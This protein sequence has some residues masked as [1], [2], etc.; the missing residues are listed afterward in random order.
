MTTQT[1]TRTRTPSPVPETGAAAVTPK[2]LVLVLGCVVAVLAAVAAAV[3]LF[4]GGG[5]GTT[6]LTSV[7]SQPTE[8]YGVG[9]TGSTRSSSRSAI[10]AR[11]P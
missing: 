4:A 3:G 11:T 9:C 10:E 5:P 6:E 7:R 2:H 8:L 1:A